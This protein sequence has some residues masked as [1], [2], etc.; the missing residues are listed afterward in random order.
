[1][2]V[3]IIVVDD[4]SVEPLRLEGVRV[5]RQVNQGPYTARLNGVSASTTPYIGFVDADDTVEPD[6]YEKMLSFAKTE[7]LD[8]VQCDIVGQ[9][10]QRGNEVLKDQDEVLRRYVKPTLIKGESS[11]FVWNKLYRK[12]T[13]FDGHVFSPSRILMF[14][15]LAINLQAFQRVS[16]MGLLHHGLYHYEVNSGSSVRNFKRKNVD[17]FKEAIRFRELYAPGFGI[18]V[19]DPVMK[20]WISKNLRNYVITASCAPCRSWR[21]RMSNVRYIYESIVGEVP[22]ALSLK[23]CA[24]RFAKSIQRLIRR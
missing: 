20:Q 4:G 24:I 13:C 23:V 16:R 2:P 3:D 19:D 21:E 9:S 15:D 8:V 12:A 10:V 1:M 7:D 5:I 22:A 11:A 18:D 6:M 14:E 17:D